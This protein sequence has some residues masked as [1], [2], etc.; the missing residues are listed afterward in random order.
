MG[1]ES[2]GS[3]TTNIVNVSGA[4][5][6]TL[7]DKRIL[8]PKL[9]SDLYKFCHEDKI[10][11]PDIWVSNYAFATSFFSTNKVKLAVGKNRPTDINSFFALIGNS[12]KGK[13]YNNDFFQDTI[14]DIQSGLSYQDKEINDFIKACKGYNYGNTDLTEEKK[15]G[16][17]IG[18]NSSHLTHFEKFITKEITPHIFTTSDFTPEALSDR[19]NSSRNNTLMLNCNEFQELKNNIGRTKNVEDIFSFM[20]PY[21]EGKSGLTIRKGQDD[22]MTT[23]AKLCVLFNTPLNTFE[24]LKQSKFFTSGNGYRYFFNINNDI[25]LNNPNMAEKKADNSSSYYQIYQ[26]EFAPIIRTFLYGMIYNS[27]SRDYQTFKINQD[28]TLKVYNECLLNLWQ[29]YVKNCDWLLDSQKETLKARLGTMLNKCIMIVYIMNYAYDNINS[30]IP[31]YP[32]QNLELSTEDILKGYYFYSFYLPQMVNVFNSEGISDLTALQQKAI[33]VLEIGE[34]VLI[35]K[36]KENTVDKGI[37]KK[38]A[39]YDLIKLKSKQ[40]KI[41]ENIKHGRLITRNF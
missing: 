22:K 7:L 41:T 27:S 4:T 8:S 35:N 6:T 28:D 17:V 21:H 3:T 38:T 39:F 23:N 29:D 1:F 24:E 5:I 12:G 14:N 20:I 18:Y 19:F 13:T 25:D 2:S 15:E 33:E 31:I 9:Y 34:Q 37:I 16:F 26:G 30:N 36:F 40:F 11:I 10:I 32:F